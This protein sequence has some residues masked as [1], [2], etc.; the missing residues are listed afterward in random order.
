MPRKLQ[1]TSPDV[2]HFLMSLHWRETR[3]ARLQRVVHID[4]QGDLACNYEISRRALAGERDKRI[5]VILDSKVA[6][7]CIAKGGSSPRALD[8]QLCPDSLHLRQ[9]AVRYRRKCGMGID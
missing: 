6:V 9:G 1:Q 5:I 3:N 8:S 7:G 4:I 2:D